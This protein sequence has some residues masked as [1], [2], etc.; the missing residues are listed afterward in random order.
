MPTIQLAEGVESAISCAAVMD[1]IAHLELTHQVVN[2]VAVRVE[3][4]LDILLLKVLSLQDGESVS[5][6]ARV[7]KA[8]LNFVEL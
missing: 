1:I 2:I 7:L 8:S 5:K 4:P 6:L 3:N